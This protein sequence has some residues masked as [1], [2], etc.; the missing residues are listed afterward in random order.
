MIQLKEVLEMLSYIY[1][2]CIYCF[3]NLFQF[4]EWLSGKATVMYNSTEMLAAI[5]NHT[6]LF[7]QNIQKMSNLTLNMDGLEYWVQPILIALQ[8]MNNLSPATYV[9]FEVIYFDNLR[10]I[11]AF[12]P[13][14]P[15]W[16]D[17]DLKTWTIPL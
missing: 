14:R 13:Y 5:N 6:N 12:H 15:V 2:H 10:F 16:Y 3:T 4:E 11:K 9:N 1:I 7:I 8:N 17:S